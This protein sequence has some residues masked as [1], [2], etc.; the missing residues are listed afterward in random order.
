MAKMRKEKNQVVYLQETHLSQQEHDKL[1]K[2][3]HR[4]VFFSSFRKGLKR[5]VAILIS[6]SISFEV[7]KEINDKEGIYVIVKGK[8]D[9]NSDTLVKCVPPTFGPGFF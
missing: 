2:V 7:F 6:N 3:R 8:L 9:D 1:K 4:N 5:S